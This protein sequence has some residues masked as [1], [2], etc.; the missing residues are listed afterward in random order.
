MESG[1]THKTYVSIAFAACSVLAITTAA[2]AQT[3]SAGT[4]GA[5]GSAALS[6]P[7]TISIMRTPD[8]PQIMFEGVVMSVTIQVT[9]AVK[10]QTFRLWHANTMDDVDFVNPLLADVTASLP[11]GMTASALSPTQVTITLKEGSYTFTMQRKTALDG[12][13]ETADQAFWATGHQEQT[14][15]FI[16]DPTA[17]LRVGSHVVSNWVTDTAR[18]TA[19]M[20]N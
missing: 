18:P 12:A 17:G 4:V 5:A 19:P 20:T 16:S 2:S 3:S 1:P 14:D 7:S 10:G 15:I 8:T 13:T 11:E 9:N 6:E